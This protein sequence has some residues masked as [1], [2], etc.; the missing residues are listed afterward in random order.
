MTSP[1]PR[2]IRTLKRIQASAIRLALAEG[3]NNIT[4]ESI[5][6]DAGISTRTFFN[7]YPY[8]EAAIMGPPPDYPADA[9]ERFVSGRGRLIDDLNLLIAAHLRRF[10]DDREMI[11]NMLRLS[12][13]DAK[14]QALR[15]NAVLARRAQL[16]Q[17]LQRRMPHVRPVM[18]DI[19][20]SAII[21]ATNNATDEWAFGRR[22]DF[23]ELARENLE[24]ILPSA[25]L[26]NAPPD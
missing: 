24:L 23:I 11:A 20:A 5:A 21:A 2:R 25:A 8:K 19:L 17:M 13:T 10:V 12:E 18:A 16:N 14:L 9:T 22:E 6:R 3:L 15:K 1:S 4:T 26:L 7:H